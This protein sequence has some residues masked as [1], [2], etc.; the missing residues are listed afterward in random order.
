MFNTIVARAA[1]PALTFQR[2]CLAR[3]IR[4]AR[5]SLRPHG[6]PSAFP[7]WRALRQ[8]VQHRPYFRGAFVASMSVPQSSQGQNTTESG[9]QGMD[10]KNV[11]RL[12]SEKK[13]IFL[14]PAADPASLSSNYNS[15][16]H[17][18]KL[19][20]SFAKM[21]AVPE[22]HKLRNVSVRSMNHL[23]ASVDALANA[24]KVMIFFGRNTAEGKLTPDG[25]VSAAVAAYALHTCYKVP[26][27][28]CDEPNK[29]LIQALLTETHPEF[30][31]YVIYLP[32][33]AV[34]GVLVRRLHEAYA[35]HAP[36]LTLYID[37]P[38]R[39]ANGDYL[40]EEG[41]SI[42]QVNVAFDQALNMQNLMGTR[43]IAIC[44]SV[45]NAGFPEAALSG[46]TQEF[47]SSVRA[48]HALVVPDVVQGTLGLME[49]L[50]SACLDSEAYK[51]EWL[52]RNINT[53][54][55]LTEDTSYT[56][57][58][59]RSRAVPRKPWTPNTVSPIVADDPRVRQ[60]AAYQARTGMRHITWTPAIEKSKLEGPKVRHAVLFDSSDGVLIA[61][62]DFLRYVRARSNFV[63][64]V[65]AVAD[66]DKA[67]YGRHDKKRLFDIVVD[68]IAYSATLKA[69]VIVMVCNTAC[70]VD[71]GKVRTAVS[72]W[73]ETHGIHGYQVHMIDLVKTVAKSVLEI[74]GPRPTLLTTEGTMDSGAYPAAIESAANEKR[75]DV[76]QVTVIG[77]GDRVRKPKK[78][79]AGL[80]NELAHIKEKN[81]T[82]YR[83]LLSE[84]E[85][86][87][88]LIPLN[89]T[90]IWLCCTHFPALKGLVRDAVNKRLAEDGL[91]LD[92]IP[93][94][95]PLSAQADETIRFLETQ[96]ALNPDKDYQDL[97][98]LRVT[99]TGLKDK[100]SESMHAHLQRRNVPLF[101]VRFPTVT[102]LPASEPRAQ[103]ARKGNPP[104]S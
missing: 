65:D 19:V 79:L 42:A 13:A 26:I 47:A 4:H 32:I 92:S 104:G 94:I 22:G 98:D 85:H 48:T 103:P 83:T 99:S 78:D 46:E 55:T 81:P 96:S 5:F 36:D 71:L 25:A 6:V 61:A 27:I 73:L 23:L 16:T 66:H 76:P 10:D 24:N 97:P 35:D 33:N 91:P 40:N 18:V 77:C 102:V 74:G 90:S 29:K 87:V 64:K 51:P 28:V 37:V 17:A 3:H 7:D 1:L 12:I 57:P 56:A 39:N 14:P 72:A 75:R 89:S 95:D 20:E 2:N 63:L 88:A 8:P 31:P 68:G 45:T 86:Y 15:K 21:M 30:G 9:K 69:D 93:I 67:S 58:T 34:N 82:L 100:V 60:L 80:V 11:I 38:G 49:L 50:C 59:L 52:V 44:G 62:D 101:T 53:A 43:S 84:V 54:N 70:T 41:D